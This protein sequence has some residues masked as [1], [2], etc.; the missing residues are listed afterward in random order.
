M[1]PVT[2]KPRMPEQVAE[3]TII[4]AQN[5]DKRALSTLYDH[6]YEAVYRFFYYRTGNQQTAEDL[7]SEVFIKMMKALPG[8]KIQQAPFRAWLFKI[9]RFHAID[10]YRS[11]HKNIEAPLDERPD[12]SSEPLENQIDRQL[13]LE[14]LRTALKQLPPDQRDVLIFRFLLGMPISETAATMHRSEDSVKGLQRR[15]LFAIRDIFV[16]LEFPQ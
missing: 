13:T 15:G 10:H 14:K 5:G 16:H 6:F 9:A 2:G 4:R 8:Y 3:Q 12:Q 1:K 11:N 7:T